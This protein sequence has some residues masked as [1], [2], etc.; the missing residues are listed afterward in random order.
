MHLSDGGYD[1]CGFAFGEFGIEGWAGEAAEDIERARAAGGA[2]LDGSAALGGERRPG[3]VHGA[4]VLDVRL[5]GKD[6]RAARM[7]DG[8]VFGFHRRAETLAAFLG[9]EAQEDGGTQ[10]ARRIG[11]V[12]QL[13][14]G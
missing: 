10:L 6:G 3:R 2:V 9:V 12:A 5:N 11:Q 1:I 13:D 8:N 7:A 4:F 14:A